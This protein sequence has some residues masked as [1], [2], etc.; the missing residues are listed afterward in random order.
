MDLTWG[1][2]ANVPTLLTKSKFKLQHIRDRLIRLSPTYAGK[3][4]ELQEYCSKL[5]DVVEEFLVENSDRNTSLSELESIDN[6]CVKA[7]V[8]QA[9]IITLL[10]YLQVHFPQCY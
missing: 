10:R 4:V 8:L 6:T 9:I 2:K 5:I 3:A 1:L 7:Q